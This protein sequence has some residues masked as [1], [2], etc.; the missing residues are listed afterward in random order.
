LGIT[1]PIVALTA[2][3]VAG[4]KETLIEAG[5]DDYLCKPIIKSELM[6]VLKEWIPADKISETT[7][8]IVSPS[9]PEDDLYK[10][11]WEHIEHIDGLSVITGLGRVYGQRDVY[12]KTLELTIHEIAKTDKNLKEFLSAK[13][14][15]NFHIEVHGI[16]STLANIGAMGL[17]SLAYSLEMASSKTDYDSCTSNLPHLLEGMNKLYLKLKEAFS[18]I[19]SYDGQI[20]IPPE[21]PPIFERMIDAF[22]KTDV[23]ALYKEVENLDALNLDGALKE[24]IEH[25]KDY[26]ILMDYDLAKENIIQLLDD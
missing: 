13:D 3:A 8:E 2:S 10:E 5:M 23:V 20:I 12:K 15:E 1:V 16:K 11:F 21:I 17:S 19:N 18:A 9:E 6:R 4:V 22:I 7:L 14:M 26:V 24:E 25:I